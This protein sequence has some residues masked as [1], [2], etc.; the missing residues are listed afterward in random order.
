MLRKKLLTMLTPGE[1]TFDSPTGTSCS[2]VAPLGET[3]GRIISNA[4]V[5]S[6]LVSERVSMNYNAKRVH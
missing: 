3:D 5:D 2:S 6:A 1:A 4:K